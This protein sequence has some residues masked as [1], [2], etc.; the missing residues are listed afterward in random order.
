MCNCLESLV[1]MA[2]LDKAEA[3]LEELR[4]SS[5]S[6]AQKD[7]AEVTEFAKSQVSEGSHTLVSA[8]SWGAQASSSTPVFVQRPLPSLDNDMVLQRSLT[9]FIDYHASVMLC[10]FTAETCDA[11]ISDAL[12][13]HHRDM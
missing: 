13:F 8:S 7:M 1:Q 10:V 3:L 12:C 9:I 4:A 6:A 2:S 11:P 5:M